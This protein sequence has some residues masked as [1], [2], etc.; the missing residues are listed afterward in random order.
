M[1]INDIYP[2]DRKIMFC[3]MCGGK[4]AW[5]RNFSALRCSKCGREH[6]PIEIRDRMWK[7]AESFKDRSRYDKALNKDGVL[8]ISFTM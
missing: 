3:K 1:N 2:I 6:D 7:K 4:L 8:E 5:N